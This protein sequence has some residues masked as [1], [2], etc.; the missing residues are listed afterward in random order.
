MFLKE[1]IHVLISNIHTRDSETHPMV[2]K[3]QIVLQ[4]PLAAEDPDS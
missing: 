1:N 4:R 3:L 2:Q